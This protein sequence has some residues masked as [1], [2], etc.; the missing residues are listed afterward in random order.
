MYYDPGYGNYTLNSLWDASNAPQFNG[1]DEYD[2]NANMPDAVRIIE[3]AVKDETEDRLFYQYMIS[4]APAP[5]DKEIIAAIRDDEMKH[6]SLFRELYQRL[7]GSF[8]PSIQDTEFERPHSYCAGLHTALL[9][10]QNAVAKYRR[11]SYAMRDRRD[12][13]IMTE[14]ITDELRHFGLYNYLYAK[15]NCTE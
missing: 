14:I 2:I 6:Y 11:I 12:I 10:E 9:G 15:N 8:L 1:N 13:N 5:K 3:N 7:T 4:I